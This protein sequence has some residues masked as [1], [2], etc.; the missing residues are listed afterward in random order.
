MIIADEPIF[1]P[2][3]DV[4]VGNVSVDQNRADR[5]RIR[6]VNREL[7]KAVGMNQFVSGFG[8]EL[9]FRIRTNRSRS[10]ER[11]LHVVPAASLRASI[12]AFLRDR[13]R[14]HQ[15]WIDT[16]IDMSKRMNDWTLPIMPND[17][18]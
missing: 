5:R 7:R 10:K 14:P 2:N 15:F 16:R 6:I 9:R 17:A 8:S 1:R 12:G 13:C 3:F 18:R 4:A 11:F